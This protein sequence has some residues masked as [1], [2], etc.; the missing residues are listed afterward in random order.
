MKKLTLVTF[1][2]LLFLVIKSDVKFVTF[3]ICKVF[4]LNLA[5]V[6]SYS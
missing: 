6:K 5:F 4:S 3:S 2:K 1:V